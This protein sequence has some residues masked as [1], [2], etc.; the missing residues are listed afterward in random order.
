MNPMARS[1]NFPFCM[2]R[3]VKSTA[4]SALLL[5]LAFGAHAQEVWSLEKC[6]QYAQDNNLTVKQA[7]AS[8][9]TAQL[10][11]SQAKA[12]R[13]PNVT[14]SIS[15]GENFG[16]TIDPTTNAF[17]SV[18]I[19]QSSV[20]LNAGMPL[21]SGGQIHHSVKQAGWNRRAAETDVMQAVND[22]SLQVAQAYLTVLLNQEQLESAKNRLAQSQRQLDATLKLIDAGSTPRAERYTI[23]AQ[24]AREEQAVV[25]AQNNLDLAYLSLKQLLQLEPDFNLEVERP[26]FEIPGD[27]NP[28]VLMLG[29]VYEQ[30]LNTQPSVRSTEYRIQAAEEGV[31]MARAS[32]WPSITLGANVNSY[33]STA[34]QKATITQGPD[35]KVV[36]DVEIGGQIVQVGF[37]QPTY[38][39]TL[40]DVSYFTQLDQNFGQGVGISVNIPIYQNGRTR[41]GVEQAR[42]GVINAQLQDNQTR[43]RLKNDIQTAIANARSARLQM[44]AAQKTVDAT[45]IAYENTEKRHSLGAV[46][47]LELTTAKNNFDIAEND[48]IVA[49]YDYLFRLKILDFYQGKALGLK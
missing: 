32:Y 19:G 41:L 40:S 17:S 37:F 13:L 43:Q 2:K 33:Y 34:F 47:T 31:K 10:S 7:E 18:A 46:N 36:Q 49:K 1:I 3:L 9:R 12:S 48:L 5:G 39:T 15:A 44:I 22:L 45:R 24:I 30:A 8:V 26:V 4:L 28:D 23:D 14:G 16:R 21:F 11:E 35:Q 29:P 20:G 27:A 6:I 38:S 25:V 42:L